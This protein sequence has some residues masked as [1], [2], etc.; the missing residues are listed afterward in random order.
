MGGAQLK[1]PENMLGTLSSDASHDFVP[2][3]VLLAWPYFCLWPD[4]MSLKERVFFFL[5]SRCN[6]AL[7]GES[8]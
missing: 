3:D 1:Q 8:D 6:L 2:K 4:T 7:N 5:Q